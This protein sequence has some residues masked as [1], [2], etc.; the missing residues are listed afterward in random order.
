MVFSYFGDL[1][2]WRSQLKFTP[3]LKTKTCRFGGFPGGLNFSFH[4]GSLVQGIANG[5]EGN[6]L[7]KIDYFLIQFG[8]GLRPGPRCWSQSVGI[9]RNFFELFRLVKTDFC[10][11]HFCQLR[12]EL[13]SRSLGQFR[14]L[15]VGKV[16]YGPH[17]F[18]TDY[19]NSWLILHFVY[20]SK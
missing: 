12:R 5:V 3:E 17:F 11:F 8:V 7:L 20:F 9:S 16:N 6:R 10:D 18:P 4:C 15:D 14:R 2:V 19:V 1:G 13:G